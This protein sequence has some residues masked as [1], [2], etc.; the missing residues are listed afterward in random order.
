MKKFNK[1]VVL[2]NKAGG[3][4]QRTGCKKVLI[5]RKKKYFNGTH[6]LDL[7]LND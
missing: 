6:L 4:Q 2:R 1:I 3:D 7:A 5:F